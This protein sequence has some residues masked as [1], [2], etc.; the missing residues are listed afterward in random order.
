MENILI[1][2][3]KLNRPSSEVPLE[4]NKYHQTSNISRILVGNE[5]VDHSHVV[6]PAP[7]Q[8]F[9]HSHVVGPAPVQLH[10][11]LNTWLQWIGQRQLEDETRN[12]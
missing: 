5:T 8:L 6:G 4:L 11:R 3:A 9:D 12:I 7:V 10:S 2:S 1:S